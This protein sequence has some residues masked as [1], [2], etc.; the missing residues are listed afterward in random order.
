MG[1]MYSWPLPWVNGVLYGT[2]VRP[3]IMSVSNPAQSVGEGSSAMSKTHLQLGEPLQHSTHCD[4]A[5]GSGCLSRHACNT[6]NT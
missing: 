2:E 5:D 6:G 1:H 4:T 3:D